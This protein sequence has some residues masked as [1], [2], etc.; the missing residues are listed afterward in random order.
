MIYLIHNETRLKEQPILFS[1]LIYLLITLNHIIPMLRSSGKYLANIEYGS[2]VVFNIIAIY[3]IMPIRR[4][5]TIILSTSMSLINFVI[6][7]Y[8]L[9]KSNLNTD[10]IFKKVKLFFCFFPFSSY[11][12]S[13]IILVA[14]M[15]LISYLIIY[16]IANIYG[17]YHKTLTSISQKDAFKNTLMFIRGRM[18][19]EKEKQQQVQ[20]FLNS[21]FS[22]TAIFTY[23]C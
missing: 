8:F 15:K 4:A 19:L 9:F 7:C 17:V 14:A 18:K 10:K 2:L 3:S 20:I 16:L 1:I 21:F 6:L 11:F 13:E 5:F 12:E 22:K 23:Y